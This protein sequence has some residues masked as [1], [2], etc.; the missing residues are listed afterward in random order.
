M[1][2][3]W[4]GVHATGHLISLFDALDWNK[5]RIKRKVER[6]GKEVKST[7]N[8]YI[9]VG[10]ISIF[11]KNLDNVEEGGKTVCNVDGV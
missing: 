1:A 5:R 3:G 2:G 9:H 7:C 11:F 6:W 10:F 8:L 4:N